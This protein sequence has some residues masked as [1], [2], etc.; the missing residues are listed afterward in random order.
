MIEIRRLDNREI[1][2][3]GYFSSVRECLV[4]GTMSGIRFRGANLSEADLSGANLSGTDLS[5]TDLSEADLSGANL[6]EADLS[7]AN[8]RGTDLSRTDLSEADL[9]GAN[10]S[11]TLGFYV[12]CAYDTSKRI[13]YCVKHETTWMVKAGCFWGNLEELEKIV[14]DTHGSKVYL[15]NIELLKGL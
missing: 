8:L 5:R 12:F 10:L 9:S 6:S 11:G 2:H 15:S 14:R 3:S 1:I 7:G 4:D 13:V